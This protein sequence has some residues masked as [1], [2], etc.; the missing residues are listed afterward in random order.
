[1]GLYSFKSEQLKFMYN[2]WILL[3]I[4]SIG[5]FIPAMTIILNKPIGNENYE[6]IVNQILQSFYLGQVGFI[7]ISVLYFGQEFK[8]STLRTSMLSVPNRVK[9]MLL[10]ILTVFIWEIALLL[11][12]TIFS[13]VIV[14]MYFNL[15]ISI[16]VALKI[17]KILIP[18]YIATFQ[19]SLIAFSL[20]GIS[21]SIVVSLAITLAMVL[22][23]GQM[24]LQFN[25]TFVYLPVLS[26]MN[27]FTTIVTSVYPSVKIG[28]L[29]QGVWSIGLMVVVC[30]LLKN[31]AIR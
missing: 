9:F 8:N 29:V 7:V 1:M 14:H 4:L 13:L 30:L 24:L 12:Y 25:N 19:I 26:V 6:F 18:V 22:G 27:A 31:R 15:E 2:K 16:D 28:L 17:I 23:L 21:K 11:I 5:V 3:T 10:K 20:T